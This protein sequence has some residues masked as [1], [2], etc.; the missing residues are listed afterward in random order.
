M[1]GG[2]FAVEDRPGKFRLI[3]DRRPANFVEKPLDW[4]SLH[5]GAMLT[6][7]IVNDTEEVRGSGSYLEPYFNHLRQHPGVLSRSAFG[8]RVEV[9]EAAELGFDFRGPSRMAFAVTG[10]GGRNSPAFA[11]QVHLEVLASEGVDVNNLMEWGKPL[12]DQRLMCGVFYDD[13]VSISVLPKEQALKISGPDVEVIDQSRRGYENARLPLSEDKAFGY[14][15][16]GSE[17]G[18]SLKFTAWGTEVNSRTGSVATPALKRS[19]LLI[20]GLRIL[21]SGWATGSFL[22]RL[23]ACWVHPFS[24]R[25]ELFAFVH[26]L[27]KYRESMGETSL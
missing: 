8:R 15:G 7:I 18:G 6:Q 3:F 23:S 16:P 9:R 17:V 13:L 10:M 2:L 27:H 14:T 19:L 20:V 4:L 5:M 24:H 21:E 22:R 12:P 25:R 1:L 26:R 11:Q